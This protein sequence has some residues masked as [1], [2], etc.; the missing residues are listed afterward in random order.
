MRPDSGQA[1][2][3][4]HLSVKWAKRWLLGLDAIDLVVSHHCVS[5]IDVR[6]DVCR[7]SQSFSILRGH[8]ATLRRVFCSK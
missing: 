7:A 8:F 3:T 1:S 4:C 2:A 5:V 6:R